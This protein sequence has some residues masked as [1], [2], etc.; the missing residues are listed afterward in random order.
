MDW[1]RRDPQDHFRVVDRD[2][3]LTYE[4]A[5]GHQLRVAFPPEDEDEVR[6][7]VWAAV[8]AMGC[9]VSAALTIDGQPTWTSD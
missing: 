8:H 2:W 9:R 7:V 4:T 3:D 5:Y 1:R 6:A